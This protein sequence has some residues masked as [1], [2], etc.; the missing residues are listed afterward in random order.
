M[1]RKAVRKIHRFVDQYPVVVYKDVIKGYWVSCPVFQGC[2][3]Q[4][5]T[6]DEALEGIREAIV[7]CKDDLSEKATH[8]SG[9]NISLHFVQA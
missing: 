7:L 5:E 2:Y 6:I 3:S 8:Y 1:K 4:G 9:K